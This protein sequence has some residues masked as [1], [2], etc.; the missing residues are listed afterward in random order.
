MKAATAEIYC[1]TVRWQEKG[2]QPMFRHFYPWDPEKTDGFGYTEGE[3]KAFLAG[4]QCNTNLQTSEFQTVLKGSR[5]QKE[6]L[7]AAGDTDKVIAFALK[8]N[9]RAMRP[10]SVK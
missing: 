6:M 2:R 3:A 9:P 8:R 1:W 7:V 5:E 4:V 10:I